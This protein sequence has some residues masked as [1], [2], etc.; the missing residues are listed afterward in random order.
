MST[1][2][3]RKHLF[4]VLLEAIGVGAGCTV[5]VIG[6]GGE[7]VVPDGNAGGV[8]GTGGAGGAGTTGSSSSAVS[9]SS[10]SSA[11]STSV[12]ATSTSASTGGSNDCTA[13]LKSSDQVQPQ[14]TC[15]DPDA[16]GVNLNCFVPPS[17]G[18]SCDKTFTDDCILSTYSCG[19]SQGGWKIACGPFPGPSGTCCY[20]IEGDCAVGRPFTVEGVARL[21]DLVP[22]EG[23]RD[24]LEPEI[25]PLDA[26]TRAALADAWGREALFEH[27][28][29]AS[30]ARFVLELLAIGAPSDLVAAAQ[31]ALSDEH[32]HARLC[33]G[34][35]SA[36]RGEAL[37]P[38]P[39]PIDGALGSS[40]DL[41]AIAA[42]LAREGC[43]AETVAALQALLARDEARDPVVKAALARIADDEVEHA[44]LA[45]RTLRWILD[46]GRSDVRSAVARVF[47]EAEAHVSLGAITDRPGD[48]AA[49]RAHG[50]LPIEERRALARGALGQII[51]PAATALLAAPASR[52]SV[53][54]LA[55]HASA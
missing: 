51:G 36:Y 12:S 27:A 17:P 54:V 41:P 28:S 39:L 38:G 45:W 29:I 40:G 35:A 16:Y 42:S 48:P 13:Y 25:A 10:S 52:A 50:Y 21:A 49:M 9:T 4:R 53:D 3:S 18:A 22:G 23:F 26:M 34:L 46:Q 15:A 30:F 32:H 55:P 14:N 19:F 33:F 11:V 37:S 8:G 43:V 31:R 5:A 44:A 6:C 24:V 20:V 47:A 7:V 2:S 1:L